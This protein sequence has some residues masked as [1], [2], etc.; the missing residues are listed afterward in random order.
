[1]FINKDSLI[2]NDISIGQYLINATYGFYDTWSEDT[3]FNT[4]SGKFVGTFK[5]TYPK[6]TLQFRKLKPE[7]IIHLTNTIF[8]TQIQRIVF[9]DI[10]GSRKT[11]NTHKGDLAIK[12]NGIN[13]SDGF[14]FD[15]VGN[16]PL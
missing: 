1:M 13:K 8:R 4:L 3:G 14:T 9:D 10:D 11:I 12:F 6:I 15:F 7:E 2:I 5:G 16:E